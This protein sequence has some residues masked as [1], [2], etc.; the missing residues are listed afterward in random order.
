MHWLDPDLYTPLSVITIAVQSSTVQ[1]IVIIMNI[2]LSWLLSVCLSDTTRRWT[3][4]AV[5]WLPPPPAG[6]AWAWLYSMATCTPAVVRTAYPASTMSRGKR[7]WCRDHTASPR[8]VPTAGWKTDYSVATSA[9][10]ILNT[11]AGLRWLQWTADGWVWAS[12]CWVAT[13]TQSEAQTASLLSTQVLACPWIF[14]PLNLN[15]YRVVS[16]SFELFVHSR[17]GNIKLMSCHYFSFSLVNPPWHVAVE[18]YDP[19]T[20]TWAKM[21]PMGTHRKHLGVAVYNNMIYAVGGR[22]DS[23]ELSSAERFNPQTNT[24]QPVVAM[25]SRRSGVRRAHLRVEVILWSWYYGAD[26][27]AVFQVGLSVV[28]GQ[29]VAIGGFDG[30]TYLKTIEILDADSNSWRLCGGMNYRRLGGGVGVVKMSHNDAIDRKL[31][32]SNNELSLMNFDPNSS[33]KWSRS[34]LAYLLY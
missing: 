17:T 29:L 18:R 14:L 11:T 24:W 4:G 28:N 22:D 32:R 27:I 15:L 10:T 16:P 34:I 13:S 19:R 8:S 20:N 31:K 21:P 23:S 5:R 1:I 12:P 7:R 26:T 2:C 33:L 30:A 3:D 25:T 6:Q 9:G